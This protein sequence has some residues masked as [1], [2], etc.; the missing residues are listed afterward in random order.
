MAV[1]TSAVLEGL[2]A[3]DEGIA[4]LRRLGESPRPIFEALGQYG[5]SSTRLRFKKGI[6]PDGARWK[7]SLRVLTSGGQTLVRKGA[8][9]GLLGSITHRADDT[10]AEWG[11]NKIYGAIHQMGGEIRPRGAKSL[12]FR[13]A[14]GAFVSTKR[15]RMP[16]RRFLGVNSEDG[17]EIEAITVD[18]IQAFEAGRA[19][20]A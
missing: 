13:L 11:T 16:A 10:S 14:N 4:R 1:A 20:G 2:Q 18:V 12:R 9:G 15:V 6:D 8:Q 17:R 3:L 7:P 19:G 5:E